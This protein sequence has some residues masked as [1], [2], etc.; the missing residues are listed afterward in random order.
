MIHGIHLAFR[1]LGALTVV[2]TLVFAGLKRDDGQSVSRQKPM[3]Q[4]H[5]D[6]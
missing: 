3:Q 5:P 1:A 2:S 4:Q 6:G